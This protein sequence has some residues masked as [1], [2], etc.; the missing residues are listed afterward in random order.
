MLQFMVEDQTYVVVIFAYGMMVWS[1][2]AAL[3]GS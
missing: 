3:K 1:D 2:N